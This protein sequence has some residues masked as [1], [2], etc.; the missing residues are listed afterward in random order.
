MTWTFVAVCIGGNYTGHVCVVPRSELL[1][2]KLL[3]KS[4]PPPGALESQRSNVL[5]CVHTPGAMGMQERCCGNK[6]R[7]VARWTPTELTP[8]TSA[9]L[10]QMNRCQRGTAPRRG[11]I[12]GATRKGRGRGIPAEVCSLYSPPGSRLYLHAKGAFSQSAQRCQC[13]L[14]S[15]RGTEPRATCQRASRFHTGLTEA[16]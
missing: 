8:E 4:P 2:G 15:S 9:V 6:H 5:Y 13:P 11:S 7:P 16:V 12:G 10:T 3:I 1:E 14:C